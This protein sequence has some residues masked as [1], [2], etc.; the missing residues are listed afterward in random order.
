MSD[1]E[2]RH[3]RVSDAESLQAFIR[4]AYGR[5]AHWKRDERWRWQ[6]VANPEARPGLELPT[7]IATDGEEIIGQM[8]AVRAGWKLDFYVLSEYRGRGLGRLLLEPIA[9]SSLLSLGL[10]MAPA[11]RKILKRSGSVGLGSVSHYCLF[12]RVSAADVVRYVNAK[13]SGGRGGRALFGAPFR[14]QLG[15][16]LSA[17]FLRAVGGVQRLFWERAAREF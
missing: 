9:R 8:A 2:I 7:V 15:S 1:I 12:R 14:T 5:E 16:M 11:S 13:A 17:G 4:N 3:A 10:T 6:F